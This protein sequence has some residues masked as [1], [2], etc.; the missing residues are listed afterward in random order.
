M[1]NQRCIDDVQ[2][3]A[4]KCIKGA[5]TAIYTTSVTFVLVP[6]NAA[7]ISDIVPSTKLIN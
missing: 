7:G 5:G 4:G 1:G 2:T 6:L 3:V